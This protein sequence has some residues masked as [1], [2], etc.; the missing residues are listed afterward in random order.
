MDDDPITLGQVFAAIEEHIRD[1]I[2]GLAYVGTMP[3]GIRTIPPPAVVIELAGFEAADKDPGTGQVA[4]EGRFEARVIVGQEEANCL[5]VAAFVA[6]QLAVLLRMQSW[7]LAVELAEF[8]RAERDWTRP[9]LD[10]YAVW[11]VEWVQTI[12]LGEEEWPWPNQPPGNLVFGFSPD[13]GP[14]SE[15][16]YQSPEDMA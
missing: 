16:H 14:G 5:Q 12:Y 3:E 4:V 7:G 15:H 9:E 13:T 8:V 6:A 1:A 10:G 11:V 2:P